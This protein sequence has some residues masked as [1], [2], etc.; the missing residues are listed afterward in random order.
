V[1][2]TAFLYIFIGACCTAIL[3][4]LYG[5]AEP[6]SPT[7]KGFLYQIEQVVKSL[8]VVAL[9]WVVLRLISVL[10]WDPLEKKRGRPVSHILKDIELF[11]IFAVAAIFIL[12]NIYNKSATG[13][14]A[15][16]I[17]A[18]G[19]LAYAGQEYIK[20]CIAGVIIDFSGVFKE[21]DWVRFPNGK[22]ARVK[23]ITIIESTFV[24][25]DETVLTLNNSKVLD[26]EI[27]NHNDSENG[28]FE[29]LIVTLEAS[30]PVDRAKRLLEAAAASAKGVL[31]KQ[32]KVFAKTAEQGMVAYR[33]LFRISGFAERNDT[34]HNVI[35]SILNDLKNH[36][37]SIAEPTSRLYL[38]DETVLKKNRIHTTS[39]R[40]TVRMSPLFREC[41]EDEQEDIAK[42]LIRKTYNSGDVLIA[43]KTLG[44]TMLF[45][46]EGVVEVSVN[47]PVDGK[48]GTK[49][50]TKKHITFLCT[51]DFFGEGG[52]L[53]DSPRNATITA[54]TDVIVY[55]LSRNNLKS[56]LKENADIALKISAY[57]V[58]RQQATAGLTQLA[59]QDL[60]EQQKLTKDVA[61]ALRDF[62]GL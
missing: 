17:T 41:A 26:Q 10:C 7:D 49:E 19:G 22:T 16:M 40:E 13:I 51:N 3:I 44:D 50:T 2:K 47:I 39:A 58:A 48:K 25:P 62:L 53:H 6:I 36:E 23:Q 59:L 43:E 42:N 37:L 8:I 30:I 29:E 15:M 33:V 1:K 57:L 46:A 27:I 20:D 31:K 28:Y 54:H 21:G 14:W 52:V 18:A 55:E 11:L 38:G 5:A 9:A 35:Y 60:Q 45:L 32:A 4:A 61:N 12:V 24:F 56:I 34:L